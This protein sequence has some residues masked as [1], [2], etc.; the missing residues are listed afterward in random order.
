M[1]TSSMDNTTIKYQEVYG[2]GADNN[3][4]KFPLLLKHRARIQQT[5]EDISNQDVKQQN[6]KK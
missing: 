2:Y 5:V 4:K 1:Q 3:I 6:I